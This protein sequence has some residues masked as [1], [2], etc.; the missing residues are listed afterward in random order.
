[1][2]PKWKS[3]GEVLGKLMQSWFKETDEV[4]MSS[5]SLSLCFLPSGRIYCDKMASGHSIFS[6]LIHI[7]ELLLRSICLP[8]MHLSLPPSLTFIS[9][10]RKGR[11]HV[12]SE[13]RF[14]SSYPIP[15]LS[16]SFH[17]VGVVD[18]QGSRRQQSYK[19]EGAWVCK[20]SCIVE[21]PI[22]WSETPAMLE[23]GGGLEMNF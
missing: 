22:Q 2:R 3:A 9:S 18:L 12:S 15:M 20:A 4:A 11:M 7:S 10:I 23:W 6:L 8:F 1:M 5:S 17:W 19:T 21:G 14:R 13:P 16:L